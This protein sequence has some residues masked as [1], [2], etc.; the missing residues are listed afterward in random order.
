VLWVT[1]E[2]RD[3]N[4]VISVSAAPR[5]G[6]VLHGGAGNDRL[7][8]GPGD[9]RFHGGDGVDRLF[10]GDGDDTLD[11]GPGNDTLD[12]QRGSDTA[13]YALRT[14]PVRV[15]MSFKIGGQSG[16]EIAINERDAILATVENAIGGA[17]DDEVVGG[18]GYNLLSGGP[19]G[20][21]IICGGLG[22]DTVDYSDRSTPVDGDGPEHRH[23]DAGA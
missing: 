15:D 6:A 5:L 16:G 21:D 19:G 2:G 12:G 10:G 11:G 3:L 17:G 1:A 20:A 4:D 13:S 22:V 23:R 8:G 14:N 7:T 18:E 9:D